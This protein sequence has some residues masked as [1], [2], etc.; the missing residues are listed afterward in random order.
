VCRYRRLRFTM[1][2]TDREEIAWSVPVVLHEL[3][4]AGRRYNITADEHVRAAVC[5]LA[6]LESLPR[7]EASF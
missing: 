7:L 3:P 5:R 6:Q 1:A 2:E 4:D